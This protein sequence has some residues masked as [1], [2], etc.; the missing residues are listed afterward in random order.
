MKLGAIVLDSNNS[1]ELAGFYQRLLGWTMERQFF[2]GVEWFFV[3]SPTGEGLP[4]V[5]Q[6][7]ADYQ[8]PAWPSVPGRQQ[9]MQH[10]DFYVEAENYEREIEHALS[11]GAVLSEIQLSELWKVM[12]DPA[13]HPFCI[14]P[15]PSE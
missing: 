11:C 15:L 9:Q 4:L 7:A 2:D 10:L 6:E 14:I 8:K 5:F 1:E 12:L 13:G 3:Q